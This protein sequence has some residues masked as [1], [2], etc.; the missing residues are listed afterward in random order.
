YLPKVPDSIDW[1]TKGVVGPVKNQGS[2][3]SA[4][5]FAVAE[6]VKIRHAIKTGIFLPDLSPQQL[7]DCDTS[8]VGCGWGGLAHSAFQYVQRYGLMSWHDYPY[9]DEKQ[10]CAYNASKVV[11]K[12]NGI[13]VLHNEYYMRDEVG[14]R[15][16]IVASLN[17]ANLNYYRSGIFD[18]PNCGSNP[19]QFL[20]IVGYG[21]E[22][23]LDYWILKNSWGPAWGEHGYLRISRNRGTCGINFLVSFPKD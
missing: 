18:Y 17:M 7:V 2:C 20:I 14:L 4:W 12:I 15:G 22:N 8:N 11:T 13:G 10:P 21:K 19:T 5:A 3:V 6:V 1:R 16:P 9:V 23:G